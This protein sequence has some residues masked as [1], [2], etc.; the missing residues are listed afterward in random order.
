MRRGVE[1]LQA[2]FL[3]TEDNNVL[4]LIHPCQDHTWEL[5]GLAITAYLSGLFPPF[6]LRPALV[7]YTSTP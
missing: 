7:P 1:D 3:Y 2:C 6:A 4:L 5:E